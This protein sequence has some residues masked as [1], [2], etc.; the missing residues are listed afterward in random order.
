MAGEDQ[1]FAFEPSAEPA[2]FG[3]HF[4]VGLQKSPVLTEHDKRLLAALRPAGV[5]LF[6]D[7]FAHDLPYAEWL[8]LH[9]RQL[10]EV[11]EVIERRELLI[12]IDHEGGPVL[13][14]PPPITPFAAARR[15]PE[16]AGEVGQAMGRELRSLGFNVDFAP[17]ADIDID[18]DNPVIGPRALGDS[19]QAVTSAA[20][21]FLAGLEGAGVLG[22]A[23]HFP[24]HGA[25]DVDSHEALPV[26]HDDLDVL[27]GREFLPFA[28][29]IEAG[30]PLV[31]TAHILFPAIHPEAPATLSRLFLRDVLRDEL[32]FDGVVVSDDVGMR[33]VAER[34]A[35]PETAAAALI[36]G[37]DL[38]PVCAHLADTR[39]ALRL[40]G[41]LAEAWR[42][43]RLP[44]EVAES[45]ARRIQALRAR[46]PQHAVEALPDE[47]FA[48]H[49]RLA[50]LLGED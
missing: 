31:M 17:V 43:G 10:A 26:I 5:I 45:S 32:G 40:A 48:R 41:G 11:R 30:V 36:A 50:P 4:L 44:R 9:A 21:A 28:A 46:A 8:E 33:A 18:P 7:N 35:R 42:R 37:C 29:L 15:W 34:F 23:K 19:A 27:R 16:R 6:R 22:C 49:R 39:L 2:S 47:V 24:G 38:I 3:H 20:V 12:C 14:T 13:R 1:A 25:T